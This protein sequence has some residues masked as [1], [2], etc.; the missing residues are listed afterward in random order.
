MFFRYTKVTSHRSATEVTEKM[1]FGC[2]V[3]VQLQCWRHFLKL[4]SDYALQEWALL[5]RCKVESGV[6]GEKP[7]STPAIA[8]L[9]LTL[10]Q[11]LDRQ[12]PKQLVEELNVLQVR[13]IS[14]GLGFFT[15]KS[16]PYFFIAD[17]P[18]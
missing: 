16:K 5:G 1:E 18:D 3:Y 2:Y 9:L 4:N 13:P 14:E 15:C 6:A 12:L 17:H 7:H 11:Q 8:W 10:P